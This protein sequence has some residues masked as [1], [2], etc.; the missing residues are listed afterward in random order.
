VTGFYH[1]YDDL[2]SV[3]I[4]PVTLLPLQWGNGMAGRT[5]GVEAWGQYQL[6][7]WWRLSG[8]LTH[9]EEHFRFK[10]GASGLLG[11]SQAAN[12]PRYQAQ[13]RSTMKLAPVSL[14]AWLRYVS[15]FR[16]P[17]QPGYT[18]LN[19]QVAWDV[20]PRLRLA[21]DG[22]NLLHAQH[23]EYVGGSEIPRSVLAALQWRF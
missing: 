7:P 16:D 8:G 19:A 10:P 14:D 4:T 1:D 11:T 13:L 23:V 20:S 22:R 3:E 17:H 6:T 12:D 5:F 15:D 21:L 2:R 18:E 9:L